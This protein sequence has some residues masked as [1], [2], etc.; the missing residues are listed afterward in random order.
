LAGF[1]KRKSKG[2]K[3]EKVLSNGGKATREGQRRAH[4][5][6]R[7]KEEKEESVEE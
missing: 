4:V 5:K 2:R 3:K 1:I 6:E 7:C